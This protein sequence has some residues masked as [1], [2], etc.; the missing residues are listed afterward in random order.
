[1]RLCLSMIMFFLM[2]AGMALECRSCRGMILASGAV[3]DE[4]W[5]NPRKAPY[6]WQRRWK[7]GNPGEEVCG[8]LF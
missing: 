4:V 5:N 6:F 3:G 1:M 2:N 8:A 7:L